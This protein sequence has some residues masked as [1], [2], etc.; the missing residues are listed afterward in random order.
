MSVREH[1]RRCKH[2]FQMTF[3]HNLQRVMFQSP[4]PDS[5]SSLCLFT[6][7]VRFLVSLSA[8]PNIQDKKGRTPIM[9]AAELGNDPIVSLLAQNRADLR[10]LDV[11]GKGELLKAFLL[12]ISAAC[13]TF[14]QVYKIR[15]V[16]LHTAFTKIVVLSRFCNLDIP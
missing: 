2:I 13:V 9:L 1:E 14:S 15:R 12:I 4:A 10:L 11:E 6:D 3:E 16:A 7:L 8:D 5:F